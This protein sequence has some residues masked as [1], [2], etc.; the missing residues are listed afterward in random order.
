MTHQ[1]TGTPLDHI[2]AASQLVNPEI[3]HAFRGHGSVSHP[4][5]Q[6]QR[7]VPWDKIRRIGTLMMAPDYYTVAAPVDAPVAEVVA[8]LYSQPVIETLLRIPIHTHFHC[9]R[10]RGLAR[11]AFAKEAPEPILRRLWKDR[12]P[13]FHDQL[14]ERE[15]PFLKETLLEGVLAR[16]GLLDR[17]L[18]EEVLS[19]GPTKNTVFPGEIFRHLDAELWARQ[20]VGNSQPQAS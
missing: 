13:G 16:K 8:P 7:R 11:M 6:G 2:L 14:L 3:K 12:A 10:D 1:N 15:R 18:L 4:W 17:P 19:P 5:F 9:G 20:W